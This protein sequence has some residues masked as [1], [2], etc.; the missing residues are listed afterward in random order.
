MALL[1]SELPIVTG[2]PEALTAV[3]LAVP[4]FHFS[5]AL[6]TELGYV[7][8]NTRVVPAVMVVV[9]PALGCKSRLSGVGAALVAEPP[10]PPPQPPSKP[11]QSTST[12]Q[13]QAW[14]VRHHWSKEKGWERVLMRRNSANS[15]DAESAPS[16]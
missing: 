3:D 12:A 1:A 2:A 9:N 6:L 13:P 5:T 11:K 10:P 14:R 8:T 16:L 15:F 7:G 4:S